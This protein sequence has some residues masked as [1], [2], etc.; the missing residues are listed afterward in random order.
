MYCILTVTKGRRTR[1]R[2]LFRTALYS[3][4]SIV[5]IVAGIGFG[6]GSRVQSPDRA[7]YYENPF[8]HNYSIDD[9]NPF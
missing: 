1:H 7:N 4:P 9:P 5:S 8:V 6:P 3:T 2:Q